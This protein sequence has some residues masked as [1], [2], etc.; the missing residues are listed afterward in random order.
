MLEQLVQIVGA[1][2]VLAAFVLVQFGRLSGQSRRYLALN[3]VGSA[4]LAV[5]AYHSRQW[6]FLILELAWALVSGT[7]LV[8]TKPSPRPVH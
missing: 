6:G 1:L 3:F 5:D 4:V 8:S 7:K 2:S